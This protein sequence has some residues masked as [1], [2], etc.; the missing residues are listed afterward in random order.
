MPA[1]RVLLE[2]LAEFVNVTHFSLCC[3]SSRNV[4]GFGTPGNLIRRVVNRFP[5]LVR[6]EVIGC[7]ARI[8]KEL[9][10]MKGEREDEKPPLPDPKL[11]HV[12]TRFCHPTLAEIWDQCPN[13]RV[14]EMEGGDGEAFW[15]REVAADAIQPTTENSS[16]EEVAIAESL[17]KFRGYNESRTGISCFS[18]EVMDVLETVKIRVGTIAGN[19]VSSDIYSLAYFFDRSTCDNLKELVIQAGFNVIK[20]R[21]IL[22]G[23]RGSIVERLA[24]VLEFNEPWVPREFDELLLD[25]KNDDQT[26]APS[27][28][29][30]EFQSLAEFCVPCGSLSVLSTDL[31]A[32]LLS[33]APALRHL[34]F[35]TADDSD[36][37]S[38]PAQR[39]A[40]LISTLE[41]VSWKNQAT[42][43][44]ERQNGV[45]VV[46]KTYAA[47]S[48][49]E[50]KGIGKWWEI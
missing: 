45:E 48:W 32:E 46:R 44:V 34:F 10:D 23:L 33:H 42:F 30:T 36:T 39:Y 13:V 41:S 14:V 7:N 43:K 12:V 35:D 16:E 19:E 47:P 22:N 3:I 4:L 20:Y 40:E 50:W 17:S 21:T 6:I 25:L 5:S 24:L 38:A 18:D 49:Q 8:A 15:R 29:F 28:F 31:L 1:L 27:R 37:L 11:T 2:K 9:V 26:N